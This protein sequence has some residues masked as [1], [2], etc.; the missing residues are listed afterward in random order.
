MFPGNVDDT[1]VH[2]PNLCMNPRFVSPDLI[3]AEEKGSSL[4]LMALG[5]GPPSG[6]CPH[7]VNALVYLGTSESKHFIQIPT[8]QI[9]TSAERSPTVV[10]TTLSKPTLDDETLTLVGRKDSTP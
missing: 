8:C 2:Y 3:S 9:E 10:R 4:R 1:S 5:L 6:M 7:N